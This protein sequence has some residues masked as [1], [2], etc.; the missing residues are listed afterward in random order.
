M[1]QISQFYDDEND[2]SMLKM[3]VISSMIEQ[4]GGF[5]VGNLLKDPPS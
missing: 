3:T 2:V 1:D 4:I 5:I